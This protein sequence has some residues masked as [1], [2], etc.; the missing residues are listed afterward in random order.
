MQAFDLNNKLFAPNNFE[1]VEINKT[2]QSTGEQKNVVYGIKNAISLLNELENSFKKSKHY[3]EKLLKCRMLHKHFH[4]NDLWNTD[5]SDTKNSQ[6][7][8]KSSKRS[9][10]DASKSPRSAFAITESWSTMSIVCL[11]YQYEE[12]SKRYK[13]L[14]KAYN[15]ACSSLSSQDHEL[16]ELRSQLKEAHADITKAHET[17]LNVG[18]KYLTLKQKKLF[19]KISY[20]TKLEDLKKAIHDIL[21]TAERA[22]LELNEKSTPQLFSTY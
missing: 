12:L 14:L 8:N 9:N 21:V 13:N 17:I 1:Y 18:S 10:T 15:D 20:Q 19:Q 2:T 5:D 4:S 22:S 7:I 16:L 6:N 11:Q 3:E